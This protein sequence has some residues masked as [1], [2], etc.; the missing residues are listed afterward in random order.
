MKNNNNTF[1]VSVGAFIFGACVL[2]IAFAFL[3]VMWVEPTPHMLEGALI[4][5]LIMWLV[6]VHSVSSYLMKVPV[7]IKRMYILLFFVMFLTQLMNTP[8]VTFPFIPW[9]MF[10]SSEYTP[11][12]VRFFKY[13]GYT[14]KGEKVVL[15]PPRYF[16]TLANGR[17]VTDLDRMIK[18][19]IQFDSQ[20]Q[21]RHERKYNEL[22]E[23][24][25]NA[26]GVKKLAA[27]LRVKS[28]KTKFLTM[29]QRSEL[30]NEAL[31]AIGNRYN[32]NHSQDPI[33]SLEVMQGELDIT[34]REH[35]KT[36]WQ[37]IW[38]VPMPIKETL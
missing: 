32:K 14:Q 18:N 29:N 22:N 35:A 16:R 19:I 23:Y 31:K 2:V 21:Q 11:H 27:V 25:K 12:Q 3:K 36:K 34:Q 10:S 4:W 7:N 1:K 26:T 20:K 37:I 8:R 13:A 28:Y 24:A 30:L 38:Q 6:I 17:I 9:H 33:V 5:A 15:I